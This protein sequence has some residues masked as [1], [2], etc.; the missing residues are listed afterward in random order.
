MDI[1]NNAP[2]LYVDNAIDSLTFEK[3]YQ[4]AKQPNFQWDYWPVGKRYIDYDPNYP[5]FLDPD[6]GK[7]TNENK[8]KDSFSSMGLVDNTVLSEI[9]GLCKDALLQVASKINLK[10]KN[11]YRVRLGL[12]LSK[13]DG[14]IINMPHVDNEIPH[15]T[16]LLYLTSN[17]GETVL[18]N[19][20]YNLDRRINS[21]ERYKEIINNGG[22]TIASKIESLQNR[23]TLFQG[24]RYHSSTCPTNISE[25]ITVNYNFDIL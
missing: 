18:Y 10:I 24:N 14:K 23:F 2:A 1:L 11:I 20:M 22:F 21:A 15:Y 19:E 25:R 8:Y 6:T 9:G 5:W 17:D 16:G 12:I 4:I 7:Y 3:I 13:E